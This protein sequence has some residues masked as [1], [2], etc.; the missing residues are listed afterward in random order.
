M[1]CHSV[2]EYGE[3]GNLHVSHTHTMFILLY[4][5]RSQPIWIDCHPAGGVGE[6]ITRSL[7]RAPVL[8]GENVLRDSAVLLDNLVLYNSC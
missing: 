3:K 4:R 8:S 1:A 7:G 5:P 6:N 2:Y